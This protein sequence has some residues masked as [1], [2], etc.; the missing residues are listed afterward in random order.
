MKYDDALR[1]WGA[2]QVTYALLKDEKIDL[3]TVRIDLEVE[4]SYGC[5]CSSDAS[6]RVSV[7]AYTEDSRWVYNDLSYF[8]F[9]D[10]LKEVCEAANGAVTLE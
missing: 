7:Q 2:T 1:A 3:S 8:D 4:Q 6:A 5:S 10:F 9:E